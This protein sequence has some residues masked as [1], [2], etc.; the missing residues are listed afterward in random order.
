[1]RGT[2]PRR[3][4]PRKL[5]GARPPRA[6]LFALALLGG[7]L[8]GGAPAPA[9][10]SEASP[11]APVATTRSCDGLAAPH[12]HRLRVTRAVG[13][14]L[15]PVGTALAIG[16]S[17]VNAARTTTEDRG[18]WSI[19]SVAVVVSAGGLI[20]GVTAGSILRRR[21]RDDVDYRSRRARRFRWSGLGLVV[22]GSSLAL[23]GSLWLIGHP[24]QDDAGDYDP[25]GL[26]M[27]GMGG[28]VTLGGITMMRVGQRRNRTEDPPP[29]ELGL[30]VGPAS[31]GLVG[32]F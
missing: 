31:L 12:V 10:A 32:R 26:L 5:S 25:S 27:I 7:V 30:R 20:T 9:R 16:A 23:T 19:F 1:M 3:L 15:L 24:R 28:A 6:R 29:V 8:A 2:L 14:S 17:A 22:F 18:F 21:C 13:W 11:D 4:E